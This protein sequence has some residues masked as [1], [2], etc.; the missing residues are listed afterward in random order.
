[1]A[2]I[3]LEINKQITKNAYDYYCKAKTYYNQNELEGALINFL[4]ALN[5]LKIVKEYFSTLTNFS[6]TISEHKRDK[7]MCDFEDDINR[8]ITKVLEYIKPLQEQLKRIKSTRGEK[9]EEA[10]CKDIKQVILEG[11]ELLSFDDVSGQETAKTQIKNSILYPLLY[12]RLYP[13]LSK[14]ILFYGPPGTGKTLLAKAFVNQLQIEAMNTSVDIRIILFAPK[15]SDLK[16][17]YVGET[18]KKISNYFKC[19][20]S[21]AYNCDK[22]LKTN[23]TDPSKKESRVISVIFIDEVEA[24]AGS[25]DK[26]ESGIMTN[27]VNALLQEMDGVISNPNVVVMAATNYPWKLDE[28]IL[29]RFDTKIYIKLPEVNDITN[30]IKT[31]IYNRYIKKALKPARNIKDI[32]STVIVNNACN[33]GLSCDT[34]V[35]MNKYTRSDNIMT[36]VEL[37]DFYRDNYF[38]SFKNSHIRSFASSLHQKKYSGGDISNVCKYVF[39]SMGNK[40]KDIGTFIE[41]PIIDPK[42][43]NKDTI[44]SKIKVKSACNPANDYMFNVFDIGGKKMIHNS[45]EHNSFIF[46]LNDTVIS[47]T[48]KRDKL[49]NYTSDHLY[50]YT[51]FSSIYKEYLEDDKYIL[52]IELNTVCS[53]IENISNVISK[54]ILSRIQ[55]NQKYKRDNIFKELAAKFNMN[56]YKKIN[57]VDKSDKEADAAA[58][59]AYTLYIK[60]FIQSI[61]KNIWGLIVSSK[62]DT[63]KAFYINIKDVF[64]IF[65]ADFLNIKQTPQFNILIKQELDIHDKIQFLNIKPEIYVNILL[66]NEIVSVWWSPLKKF[67]SN[68]VNV[69]QITTISKAS[70]AIGSGAVLAASSIQLPGLSALTIAGL[71]GPVIASIL[72]SGLA[73][74]TLYKT[75]NIQNWINS[76]APTYIPGMIDS[77]EKPLEKLLD[78]TYY[79]TF[80]SLKNDS[81]QKMYEIYKHITYIYCVE[82]SIESSDIFTSDINAISSFDTVKSGFGKTKTPSVL[83]IYGNALMCLS[84][85]IIYSDTQGCSDFNTILTTCITKLNQE[86]NSVI[87]E[88]IYT[89]AITDGMSLNMLLKLSNK[90]KGDNIHFIGTDDNG[91]G[92]ANSGNNSGT[93]SENE[94]D[95]NDNEYFFFLGGNGGVNKYTAMIPIKEVDVSFKNHISKKNIQTVLEARDSIYLKFDA[96]IHIKFNKD[97]KYY[98]SIGDKVYELY[99]VEFNKKTDATVE[100][101]KVIP[102][103]NIYIDDSLIIYKNVP[104]TDISNIGIKTCEEEPDESRKI[105]LNFDIADFYNSIH[106]GNMDCINPTTSIK[107]LEELDAYS[108]NKYTDKKDA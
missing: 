102:L 2:D 38:K 16:G 93:N 26:D 51:T 66:N 47:E 43:L 52:Y 81:S 63:Q 68:V 80:E 86:K 49:K 96:K 95:S 55:F 24:I 20:S 10:T 71:S 23:Q 6:E 30:Q 9:G 64:S 31:E 12:P 67:Y 37:F 29:R 83:Q 33:N 58:D 65:N 41:K 106:T 103:T 27:S 91:S 98:I 4:L 45:W 78:D 100:E 75:Y 13:N 39:K 104:L 19:A 74:H 14:G 61:Y 97:D 3:P 32:E 94:E 57:D 99:T 21:K 89:N 56:E 25:R 11:D 48:D 1:M 36:P 84:T 54:H 34:D 77:K 79:N 50:D 76:L 105:T 72:L 87:S 101:I 18:E 73:I 92:E 107:R 44:D 8:A 62:N 5:N 28:A 59:E 82:E 70:L 40:A 108:K 17:K 22:A 69:Q 35:C 15:G 88:K 90:Y 46:M 7:A 60:Q 85:G 42:L 53:I